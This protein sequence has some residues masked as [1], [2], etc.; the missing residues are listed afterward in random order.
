MAVIV[1]GIFQDRGQRRAWHK[2]R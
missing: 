1:D 2:R